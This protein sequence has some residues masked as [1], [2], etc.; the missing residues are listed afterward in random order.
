MGI[1][2]K[3]ADAFDPPVEVRWQGAARLSKYVDRRVVAAAS[4]IRARR[5]TWRPFWPAYRPYRRRSPACP[6]S[7]IASLTPAGRRITGTRSTRL[8]RNGPNRAADMAGFS[9]MAG[10]LDAV[11]RQRPCGN[12]TDGG[13]RRHG[14]GPGALGIRIVQLLASGRLAYDIVETTGF[15]GATGRQRRLLEG[16]VLHLRDRSDDGLIGRCRLS[17]AAAVVRNALSIQEFTGS[18]YENGVNPSGVL[19]SDGRR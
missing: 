18:L 3:I 16:E 15:Y 17:R 14:A 19:E 6:L 5:K 12:Q 8:I 4:S 13:G 1:L 2:R 7:F 11:A 10:G 9:R